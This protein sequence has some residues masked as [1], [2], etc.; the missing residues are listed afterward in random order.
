MKEPTIRDVASRAGVS[1]ATASRVLNGHA[2]T[3]EASRTRVRQAA[4]ELHY[5]PNSLARSLKSARRQVVS[6]LISDIRNPFF[7]ELAYAVQ[8][9]L[10]SRGYS[11]L[12]GNASERE[13][14]QDQHL[15]ALRNQRIDGVI[16]A[17]QGERSVELERLAA[18][19]VP[20]VFVDRRLPS[21]VV[22]VV[23]SDPRPGITQAL[24]HLRG[25][26]HARIGFVAGP[27]NTSTGRERLAVY[28]SEAGR[29]LDAEGVHDRPAGYDQD[30]CRSSVDELLAVGC[31]ALLFGYS[32]N[33]VTA[34]RHLSRSGLRIPEDV[35]I[36]SFDEIPVF[37]V[38]TPPVS[39]VRQGVA[40]MGSLAVSTLFEVLDG[41]K[42]MSIRIPTELVIRESSGT[43]PRE[44]T[45]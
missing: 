39:I 26:G 1:V 24:L 22:P 38:M 44:R 33:A 36:V 10:W 41:K 9:A 34:L 29:L 5:S 16:A 15:R 13:E 35:S 12:L 25:L 40:E 43:A 37:E 23:D 11:M 21:P 7:A 3:S 20:L 8:L 14:L 31:T 45:R 18:Q 32:P 4:A 42:P 2:S 17:P 6:L 19:G 28:R 30:L 27:H